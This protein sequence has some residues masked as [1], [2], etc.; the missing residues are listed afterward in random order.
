MRHRNPADFSNLWLAIPEP[1]VRNGVY[2]GLAPL[3]L[4]VPAAAWCVSRRRRT[5]PIS[6]VFWLTLA[7]LALVI[8]FGWPKALASLLYLLP[9]IRWNPATRMLVVYA[10]GMAVVAAIGLEILIRGT[11]RF[12]GRAGSV[13]PILLAVVLTALQVVDVGRIGREHNPVVAGHTFFPDTP[14]IRSVRKS[15]RPDQSVLATGDGFGAAGALG[16]YRLPE[17]FAHTLHVRGQKSVL[18]RLV[19]DAWVTPTAARFDLGQIRLDPVWF[20]ALGVCCV[21]FPE[22]NL[23]GQSQRDGPS[24]DM[25]PH[26]VGQTLRITHP[27]VV[28]ELHVA[29]GRGQAR[30]GSRPLTFSWQDGEGRILA[31]GDSIG[32]HADR[33]AWIRFPLEP[34]LELGVGDY[35]FE[36]SIPDGAAG[37]PVRAWARRK[38]DRYADGQLLID[39]R[40]QSGDLAFSVRGSPILAPEQW[41]TRSPGPKILVIERTESPPGAYV[42]PPGC[43]PEEPDRDCMT[44]DGVRL[45][46]HSTDHAT[47]E[48]ESKTGGRFVRTMRRW[49]G[50]RAFVNGNE[51]P[52]ETHL[53]ILPAVSVAPGRST[54]EWRYEP[55][56]WKLGLVISAISLFL[57]LMLS[58]LG[59]GP[60]SEAWRRPLH[61]LDG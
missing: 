12:P 13:V 50:W 60:G 20:D 34:P 35:G 3:A 27:S 21:L 41:R 31:S 53:G 61:E 49:P 59:R 45:L 10:L 46:E 58:I 48:I 30:S 57:V 6:P 42:V 56:W 37:R 19:R 43:S 44:W 11:S 16:A 28:R 39:G 40:P 14:T 23:F 32:T 17:W 1:G 55:V 7:I 26:R 25:P 18:S 52:L 47:Y 4:A 51:R 15:I 24:A 9:V 29:T 36:M 54:V 22:G 38:A 5:G 33:P 2:V 8:G